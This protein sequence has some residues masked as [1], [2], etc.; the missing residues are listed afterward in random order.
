MAWHGIAGATWHGSARP[1][2]ELQATQGAAGRGATLAWKRRQGSARPGTPRRG[3]VRQARH[4]AAG[5]GEARPGAERKRRLGMARRVVAWL[6]VETQARCVRLGS[7]GTGFAGLAWLGAARRG[8]DRIRRQGESGTAWLGVV[9]KRRLG[10]ACQGRVRSGAAGRETQARRDM[11]R[12]G[13][14]G[15]AGLAGRGLAGPPKART[16][17]AGG[18]WHATARLK[19]CQAGP[20]VA[21]KA[22]RGTVQ[23]AGGAWHVSAGL[24]LDAQARRSMARPGEVGIRR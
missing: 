12:L 5:S 22:R 18:A 2:Q 9:R 23:F 3:Q 13:L 20:A 6:G 11:A 7:A 8:G 10:T 17:N 15:F 14:E 16:G 4:G 1:D 19:A 21:G 24:G